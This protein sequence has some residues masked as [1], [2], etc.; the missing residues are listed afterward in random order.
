MTDSD[1]Y[2]RTDLT[3]DLVED[4]YR[5]LDDVR[6][7]LAVSRIRG[8]DYLEG[9]EDGISC[10]LANEEWWLLQLLDKVERS[11]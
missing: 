10:R 2:T 9:F 7:A 8:E 1:F 5:R 3:T 6:R 11:R 4:L